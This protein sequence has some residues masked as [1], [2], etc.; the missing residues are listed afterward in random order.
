MGLGEGSNLRAVSAPRSRRRP[1][2]RALAPLFALPL[3]L[4]F[5]ASP[6]RANCDYIPAGKSF[7]VRLLDPLA[8]YSSKPGASIRAVL[9]QSPECGSTPVFPAGLEVDGEL[10]AVHKVGLGFRRDSASLEVRFDRIVTAN[11]DVLAIGSQVVEIDNA[12]ETARHGVIHG[13][14]ATDTP[15]GRITSRLVHLPTLNPY[16]DVGLM[17]YR[18]VSV[19]PE[20]EIYLPPG[21]DLRLQ[22]TVPLYV[23]DQPDLPHPSLELDEYERGDIEMLLQDVPDRTATSSGKDADLVNLLFVGSQEQLESAFTAAGWLPGDRTSAHSVFKEFSALLTFSNYPTMPIS[24]QYLNGQVQGSTWQ[25]SLDSYN[26]REHLRIWGEPLT[27]LDQEAWLGAYTRETGAALSIRYHQF[28]HH[29]DRNVDEGVNMLV[30]DL[31]LSG[32][33]DSV[34]LMPRPTV[35]HLM[36]N[37]TGDEMR[38]DGALTVVHLK[39]CNRPTTAYTRANP[40]IPIRP[41]SR[42]V[43]YFRDEVLLYK[44]DVVRGNILYGAFDL[45]RMSIRSFRRR[46]NPHADQDDENLPLSPVSP[47]TLFPQLALNSSPLEP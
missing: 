44:S 9:I 17:V 16:S 19:L 27:V 5:A 47:E 23:G 1:V 14:R 24:K 41:H 37:A 7:W 36:A 13:I 43:R 35:H 3:C 34:R 25:K 8:S 46:H 15:Q 40:L 11:G 39:N 21:A 28:I 12:R 31:T 42:I 4:L 18:A 2:C 6:A 33:V 45:C 29:I 32:C 22:L 10:V 38:T 20:P 30:R 26:K